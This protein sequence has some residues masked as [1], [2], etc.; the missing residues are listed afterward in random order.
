M[1][2]AE[3]VHGHV[4]VSLG[5]LFDD[6]GNCGQLALEI[7][8]LNPPPKSCS[9]AKWRPPQTRSVIASVP[10][11]FTL[12]AIRV[13]ASLSRSSFPPLSHSQYLRAFPGGVSS[14]LPP[15]SN[16]DILKLQATPTP[17]SNVYP[18]YF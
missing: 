18:P 1:G 7:T 5:G 16:L 4:R 12:V 13:E 10:I 11:P 2:L 8:L 9:L 6:L 14:E 15:Y 3:H 17:P